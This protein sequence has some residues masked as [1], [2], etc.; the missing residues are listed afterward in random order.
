MGPKLNHFNENGNAVM[1]DVSGKEATD[2]T[3]LARG[4]IRV[5]PQVL[6]AILDHAVGKGDVLGVARIAGIMAVKRT[7]EFIPLCHPL[8]V[9][10]VDLNFIIPEDENSVVAECSV[11]FCGRT[12]LE[13]EALTG[14]AAALLTIYDMCKGFG[15]EMEISDIHLVHKEGG[16]SG[17][18]HNER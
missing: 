14:V 12:G 6:S 16:K 10:K 15:K 11:G 4:K 8:M 17:V 2:R 18:Y 3:A 13:M 1:V 5:S 9:S 7:W